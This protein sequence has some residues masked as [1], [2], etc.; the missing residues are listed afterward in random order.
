ML[1]TGGQRPQETC[2]L[3]SLCS[4][5]ASALCC[6]PQMLTYIFSFGNEV[7]QLLELLKG[8]GDVRV[9]TALT[10]V[11]SQEEL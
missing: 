8:R 9:T 11:G 7:F 6:N 2:L 1:V 4:V 10:L 3:L 5:W